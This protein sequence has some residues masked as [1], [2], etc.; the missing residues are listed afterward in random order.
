MPRARVNRLKTFSKCIAKMIQ[1]CIPTRITFLLFLCSH[2]VKDNYLQIADL[3]FAWFIKLWK[4]TEIH[5][6]RSVAIV[7][8]GCNCIQN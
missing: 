6:T 7:S 4:L 8:H 5:L 3:I 1:F 2:F